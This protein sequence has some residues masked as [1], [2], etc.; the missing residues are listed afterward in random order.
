MIKKQ[1]FRWAHAGLLALALSACQTA[2]LE[3]PGSDKGNGP[4][5]D[6]SMEQNIRIALF[7]A[8]EV[9]KD[10]KGPGPTLTYGAMDA[11]FVTIGTVTYMVD[12]NDLAD[13]KNLKKGEKINFR[14][15]GYIARK[16]K[17]GENFRVV[18]LNEL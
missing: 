4:V 14:A 3:A 9:K 11:H 16:E 17:T 2:S 10:G 18:R 15:N 5:T 1:L 7:H 12:W 13:F 6:F 8:D